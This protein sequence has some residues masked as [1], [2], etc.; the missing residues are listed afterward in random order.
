MVHVYTT[1][2]LLVYNFIQPLKLRL[3][4]PGPLA[5]GVPTHSTDL[6]NLQKVITIRPIPLQQRIPPSTLPAVGPS[7]SRYMYVLAAHYMYTALQY[8]YLYINIIHCKII[9]HIYS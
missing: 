7:T 6:P 4:A 9:D 3:A 2:G 8:M 5:P 1:V